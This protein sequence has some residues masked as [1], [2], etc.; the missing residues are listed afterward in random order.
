MRSK[1]IR[2][3]LFSFARAKFTKKRWQK[4]HARVVKSYLKWK[5]KL[6]EKGV[7]VG[8]KDTLEIYNNILRGLILFK[9]IKKVKYPG[10]KR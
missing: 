8:A 1:K 3:I 7:E 6:R 10:G 4:Q 9:G 5:G 2:K